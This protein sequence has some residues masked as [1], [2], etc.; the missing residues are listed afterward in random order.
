MSFLSPWFLLGLLGVGIPLAIHM[1]RRGKANKVVFSTIRFLKKTSR[2]TILF[3]QVQQWALML[4]R[5]LIVVL[6]AFAFARPFIGGSFSEVVGLAPRSV[7]ILLDTSMSMQY[8]EHFARAKEAASKTLQTLQP[9]DEAAIVAFSESTG[10]VK[11]LTNNLT[12]LDDFL[13]NLDTPGFRSTQYLPALR[14]ADQILRSAR[15]QDRTVFLISDFQRRAFQQK[16]SAWRLSPGIDFQSINIGEEETINL[17]VTDVK[18][19]V[20]LV[21]DQEEY[22]VLAR[23]RNLGTQ[24]LS[25]AE[26]SLKIDQQIVETRTVDFS[27]KSEAV[28]EFHATFNEKAVHMGEVSVEDP[29]FQPDNTF[30]FTV[31]A[32]LPIKILGINGDSSV[33]RERDESYW[34]RL[35]LGQQSASNFELDIVEAQN[36]LPDS[37]SQYQVILFFNLNAGKLDPVKVKAIESFVRSGGSFWFSHGNGADDESF[38][39]LFENL[40]PAVL[41]KDNQVPDAPVRIGEI[42]RRHPIFLPLLANEGADFSTAQF[43]RYRIVSAKSGSEV[44]MRFD[45]G[46]PAL[47]EH[48]V[49]R[50]RVLFFTSPFSASWNNLPLQVLFLP[51][52]HESLDYLAQREEKHA[53][54]TVGE[55]ITLPVPPRTIV[56]VTEPRGKKTE[57]TS[58]PGEGHH[59]RQ[60]ENPGF[61]EIRA[62]DFQDFLA[63]N[64][65]AEESDFT[66]I[67]SA[68][69]RDSVVNPQTKPNS[70]LLGQRESYNLEMEKSQRFWWWLLFLVVLL[71]FAETLLANRTYRS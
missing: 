70:S 21:P 8:G 44:L 33:E 58:K 1:I 38:H 68:E 49:G 5:A 48:S 25:E 34:F 29:N 65:S 56:H 64:V 61:Y 66:P 3:Q 52:V 4:V 63:I 24:H 47:L 15:F 13:K 50:G 57:M 7:V 10:S 14:L 43:W 59:F 22:T 19:P 36:K 39:Q 17:A 41:E 20:Q 23:V 27:D 31:N 51:W 16:D 12:E 26:V 2:K 6:L 11:G 9:G 62:E 69:I 54:Y 32:P 40:S 60:T 42:N 28:V 35:A 67:S 53:F 45:T 55:T 37:L 46:E 18:S 71:G 30:Y